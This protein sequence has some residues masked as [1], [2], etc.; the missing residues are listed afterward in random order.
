M[1]SGKCSLALPLQHNIA[2]CSFSISLEFGYLSESVGK[3]AAS[4]HVIRY[5]PRI[6]VEDL[7]SRLQQCISAGGENFEKWKCQFKQNLFS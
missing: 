6:L 5:T 2:I 1:N 4:K 7:R 3:E